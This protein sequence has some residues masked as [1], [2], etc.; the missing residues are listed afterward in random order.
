[1]VSRLYYLELEIEI[2]GV[3]FKLSGQVSDDKK[4]LGVKTSQIKPIIN[5]LLG[6]NALKNLIEGVVPEEV[7]F[8]VEWGGSGSVMKIS[9][10]F[11]D[12]T[13]SVS[14][15]KTNSVTIFSLWLNNSVQFSNLPLVGEY[16]SSDMQLGNLGFVYVNQQIEVSKG[17]Q[18]SNSHSILS[19]E[20]LKVLDL[21]EITR[22]DDVE[23]LQIGENLFVNYNLGFGSQMLAYPP[24]VYNQ[25]KLQ[26]LTNSSS[27]LS[28]DQSLGFVSQNSSKK[29]SP[30][31]IS[32]VGISTNF[33]NS[34]M[35]VAVELS[36]KLSLKKFTFELIGLNV[37]LDV[38][39]LMNLINNRISNNNTED[40]SLIADISKLFKFNI[41]GLALSY[42]T[43]TF[44][45]Y[46]G[47]YREI[48][49]NREEYNGLLTLQLKKLEIIA[50]ASYVKESSY[51]SLFAFGYLGVNIPLH[52]AFEVK[53]LAL[54]LGLNREF[55]MISNVNEI[56]KFPLIEI[57][58]N[59]GLAEGETLKSVFSR[60]NGYI[61]PKEGAYVVMLGLRFQSF[62]MIDTLALVA[63]NI[64]DGLV[65]NML[66]LST[67][68]VPNAYK[69]KFGFTMQAD[70]NKGTFI[71]RGAILKGS[72][73]VFK[74]AELT[75]SFVY[76]LWTAGEYK[77]DFL[78]TVG[79]YHPNFQPPNH[80]P[81]SSELSRLGLVFNKGNLSANLGMYFA[82]TP[83][84]IMFGLIGKLKYDLE[85]S[86][87]VDLWVKTV[88]FQIGIS[89]DISFE[90]HLIIYWKPF[91]YSADLYLM[92]NV[93][94]YANFTFFSINL[95]VNLSAWLKIWGPDLAGEG[96][97]SVSVF[98]FKVS[99]GNANLGSRKL[100]LVEFKKEFI[101][102]D[103]LSLNISKG[104]IS[105]GSKKKSAEDLVIVNP[106]DF[107]LEITSKVPILTHSIN[108]ST[109]VYSNKAFGINCNGI[110]G[111]V[112]HHI[113]IK[114]YDENS[115]QD[116]WIIE[117]ILQNMPKA[118][119]SLEEINN[120]NAISG[121]SL[122]KN[123]TTG[124]RIAFPTVDSREEIRGECLERYDT[125]IYQYKEVSKNS[126]D[127][128]ID[129]PFDDFKSL[130]SEKKIESNSTFSYLLPQEEWDI[131][132][133]YS[134]VEAYSYNS[135]FNLK[136]YSI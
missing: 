59:N 93:R 39:Y 2:Y 65:F 135:D 21:K 75:G 77:D 113:V 61:P 129:V 73:L 38:K 50:L 91:S 76:A 9:A 1:M 121:D 4:K 123:L 8:T 71:A 96:Y 51:S 68:E 56:E 49:K 130:N 45:I 28:T 118:L 95:S 90:A 127:N 97:L 57:I 79:G 86:H 60:L 92:F 115:L 109:I 41:S 94:L 36:A 105:Q 117:P 124:F 136:T 47:F 102:A 31:S 111:A 35:E 69:L 106:I 128:I 46:G 112:F 44:S 25:D 134:E 26:N 80:Y 18:K 55:K 132:D 119:W 22:S 3:N 67:M 88:Y 5:K 23:S 84:A 14:I 10:D 54:G 19:D 16:I 43:P 126:L 99:F 7:D 83:K 30:F 29:Q 98:T 72:Y 27:S 11:A 42:K 104:K 32:E 13:L 131:T 87:S 125:N 122:V 81:K 48:T 6:D 37:L 107:E 53:G 70:F 63:L 103:Y 116:N 52:P 62:K 108:N 110:S 133:L 33:E 82:L 74:E 40:S 64:D 15:Y 12:N 66:G 101:P 89:V 17:A 78:F 100:S 34:K 114:K 24:T 20:V 58:L 120:E 85:I